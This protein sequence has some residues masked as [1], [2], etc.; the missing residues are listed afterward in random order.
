MPRSLPRIRAGHAPGR[1]GIASAPGAPAEAWFVRSSLAR[2][3][4]Q[5]GEKDGKDN[6]TTFVFNLSRTETAAATVRR[7][8]G[9]AY[10]LALAWAARASE[11]ARRTDIVTKRLFAMPLK[12]RPRRANVNR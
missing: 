9:F 8:P 2:D 1:A 3:L 12:G 7:W 11:R 5:L 4:Q 6:D 10:A